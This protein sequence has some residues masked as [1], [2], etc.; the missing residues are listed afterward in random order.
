MVLGPVLC[1]CVTHA[2]QA[3]GRALPVAARHPASMIDAYLEALPQARAPRILA[4]RT[5]FVTDDPEEG[6]AAGCNR[7]LVARYLSSACR[8]TT[9]SP[10]WI[11]IAATRTTRSVTRWLRTDRARYP[12]RGS[13]ASFRVDSWAERRGRSVA[14]CG[15]SAELGGGV[16]TSGFR[17]AAGCPSTNC[18][19]HRR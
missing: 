15:S 7:Q 11:S 6:A 2:A 8:C 18:R 5:V 14:A 13:R 16:G 4:S 10:L 9:R 1:E 17:G 3:G 12:S 19:S